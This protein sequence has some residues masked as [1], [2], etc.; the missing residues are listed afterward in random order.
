MTTSSAPYLAFASFPLPRFPAP[1]K[2]LRFES[3]LL[4]RP[5]RPK[6]G[7]PDNKK[8]SKKKRKKKWSELKRKLAR[9][10]LSAKH[11]GLA[12]AA[13]DCM[14]AVED[15]GQMDCHRQAEAASR[16]GYERVDPRCRRP[17]REARCA[18]TQK[19]RVRSATVHVLSGLPR[20]ALRYYQP[21]K[22]R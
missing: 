10:P 19:L 4:V 9:P 7:R 16:G 6:T 1:V 14:A 2:L 13:G 20:V 12:E 15:R 17:A 22:H 21:L 8:G 3:G 18:E 11:A 5:W